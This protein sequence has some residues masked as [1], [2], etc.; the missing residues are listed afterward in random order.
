MGWVGGR[1]GVV[2]GA[3]EVGHAGGWAGS[4]GAQKNAL[5]GVV[6]ILSTPTVLETVFLSS[7]RALYV[8]KLQYPCVYVCRKGGSSTTRVAI[9]SQLTPGNTNR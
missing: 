8:H 5:D 4:C 3:G 2:R 1:G 7:R 9:A 6:C